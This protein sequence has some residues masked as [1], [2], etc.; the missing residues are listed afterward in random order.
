MRKLRILATVMVAMLLLTLTVAA[1]DEVFSPSFYSGFDN[2]D[3]SDDTSLLITPYSR[4]MSAPLDIQVLLRNAKFDLDNYPLEDLVTNF[5]IIWSSVTG[6]APIENA[7]IIDLVDV[8]VTGNRD[9]YFNGK[10]PLTFTISV[11]GIS[12]GDKVM[13]IHK[14]NGT[15]VWEQD[16]SVADG[17][18]T[19]TVKNLSCFAIIIDNAAAPATASTPV[20]VAADEPAAEAP[21]AEAPAAEEAPVV[22]VDPAP[23]EAEAP[24]EVVVVAEP[25]PEAVVAPV[26]A[27]PAAAEAPTSPQTGVNG[28]NV[29]IA[30]AVVMAVFGSACIVKAN[31]RHDA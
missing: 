2:D 19:I 30:A 7:A 15:W 31:R 10:S 4:I 18:I 22:V 11:P 16:I 3:F 28:V 26:D 27:A 12:A 8:T 9:I 5:A 13:V 24:V 20:V 6:G 21:A 25:E 17:K 14:T 1:S 29:A 23:A